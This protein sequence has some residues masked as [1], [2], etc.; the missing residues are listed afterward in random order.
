MANK[1][2]KK[3]QQESPLAELFR[4]PWTTAEA[5][6]IGGIEAS[7]VRNWL[8]RSSPSVHPEQRVLRGRVYH[9]TRN[10]DPE[11][12]DRLRKA[13]VEIRAS[14]E[15]AG[16]DPMR[17]TDKIAKL[18]R[19]PGEVATAELVE[20]FVLAELTRCGVAP[21]RARQLGKADL[22]EELTRRLFERAYGEIDGGS[23]RTP[24]GAVPGPLVVVEVHGDEET[25]EVFEVEPDGL[26][27]HLR[28]E[29][30]ATRIVVDP[31]KLFRRLVARIEK[32]KADRPAPR[33]HTP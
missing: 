17:V 11:R 29:T 21:K 8:A 4:G 15:K 16:E 20:A 13:A 12:E 6:E 14:L 2:S 30:A 1:T 28:E 5:A 33:E 26:L 31:A 24:G 25:P 22:I 9:W 7:T 18:M 10:A 27:E 23:R 32:V 3:A 19:E